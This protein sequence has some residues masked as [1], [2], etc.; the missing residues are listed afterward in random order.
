M[1]NYKT[2]ILGVLTIIVAVASAA[3]SFLATGSV[4]DIATLTTAVLAGWGLV[5][6]KDN[7]ARL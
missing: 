5:M 4:P 2:T 3:K 1:R 6:A 7:N